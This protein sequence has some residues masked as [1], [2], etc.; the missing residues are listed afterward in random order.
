MIAITH[1]RVEKL[2]HLQSANRFGLLIESFYLRRNRLFNVIIAS[3]HIAPFI[4]TGS[5]LR[6]LQTHIT[7]AVIWTIIGPWSGILKIEF[8]AFRTGISDS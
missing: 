5:K 2:V 8:P 4:A 3:G 6:Q 7:E 1:D